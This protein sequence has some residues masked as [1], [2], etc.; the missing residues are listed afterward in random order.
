[1]VD[2]NSKIHP[3]GKTDQ[4]KR[5][6]IDEISIDSVSTAYQFNINLG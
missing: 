5:H 1:M 3:E 2:R 4:N 6:E